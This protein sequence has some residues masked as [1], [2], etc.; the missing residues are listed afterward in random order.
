MENINNPDWWDKWVR[1]NLK[2][3]ARSLNKRVK[4]LNREKDNSQN[5]GAL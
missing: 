2:K 3:K 4:Q 5:K 1:K